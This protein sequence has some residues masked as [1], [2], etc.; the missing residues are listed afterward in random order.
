MS[1]HNYYESSEDPMCD[2]QWTEETKTERTFCFF[3]LSRTDINFTVLSLISCM[4]Q[5]SMVNMLEHSH[6]HF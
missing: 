1:M 4:H 6:V 2:P 3:R 5:S